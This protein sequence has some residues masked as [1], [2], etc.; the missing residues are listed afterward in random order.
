MT[1]SSPLRHRKK[2]KRKGAERE[3]KEKKEKKK[4]YQILWIS[5]KDKYNEWLRGE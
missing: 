4:P 5:G 1:F 3:K 2:K